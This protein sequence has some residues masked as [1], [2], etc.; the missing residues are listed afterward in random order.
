V[1]WIVIL[2]LLF[3]VRGTVWARYLT[4]CGLLRDWRHLFDVGALCCA[5][6]NCE[7]VGDGAVQILD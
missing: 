7:C 6:L 2:R 5:I 4:A 3:D 1:Y